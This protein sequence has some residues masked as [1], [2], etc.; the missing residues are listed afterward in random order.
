MII[1]SIEFKEREHLKYS[2]EDFQNSEIL[3]PMFD[4]CF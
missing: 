3:P 1:K 2:V 4:D